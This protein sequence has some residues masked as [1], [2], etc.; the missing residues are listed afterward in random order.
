MKT[1]NVRS[2]PQNQLR[3]NLY[4]PENGIFLAIFSDIIFGTA[5]MR[6]WSPIFGQHRRPKLASGFGFP[7]IMGGASVQMSRKQQHSSTQAAS[8]QYLLLCPIPPR[9]SGIITSRWNRTVMAATTSSVASVFAVAIATFT[10][11]NQPQLVTSRTT[12]VGVWEN[13]L[14]YRC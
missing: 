8:A 9:A 12:A 1:E 14:I 5:S 13:V 7:H 11:L 6:K 2:G 4:R 3:I 10:K